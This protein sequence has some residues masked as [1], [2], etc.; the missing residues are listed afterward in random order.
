M[1]MWWNNFP[2]MWM[3]LLYVIIGNKLT[4]TNVL[5]LEPEWLVDVWVLGGGWWLVG[6]P[7]DVDGLGWG[8]LLHVLHWVLVLKV[9]LIDVNGV[10]LFDA[11]LH[12]L[13]WEYRRKKLK[14]YRQHDSLSISY[15]PT[16]FYRQ[17]HPPT[18]RLASTCT[19]MLPYAC[20]CSYTHM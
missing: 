10:V 16:C 19:H 12:D 13:Q 11:V 20:A 14:L 9:L 7:K 8:T 6:A 18:Q 15:T 2:L 5:R 1:L 3:I 17:K 4:N